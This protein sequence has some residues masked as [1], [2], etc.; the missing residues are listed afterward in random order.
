M[1]LIIVG[2]E[3][4]QQLEGWVQELSSDVPNKELPR[5]RRDQPALR[6]P[7]LMTQILAKDQRLLSLEFPTLMKKSNL[8]PFPVDI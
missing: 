6:G 1:K 5:L 3:S 8:L 7:E 2:R 4:L